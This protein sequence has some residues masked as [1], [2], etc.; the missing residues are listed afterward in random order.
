MK[1][2]KL[3]QGKFAIV[4][5]F[6]FD[7]LNQW[8][9]YVNTSGY[10]TRKEGK[11][12]IRMHRLIHKTPSGF[13]TDHINREKLD[14]RRA[15]LRTVTKSQNG[16]NRKAPSNNKSGIKGVYW[17]K[18]TN[19]WRAEIKVFYKKISLGRFANIKDALLARKKAEKTY[20]EI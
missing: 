10:A 15:N 13:F 17:D 14:N 16:F 7:W 6:N 3:N 2:I 5:D 12:T 1:V 11:K 18:F 9:W 4:D 20:H 8:K 19:K